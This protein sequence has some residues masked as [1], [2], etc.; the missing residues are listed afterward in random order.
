VEFESLG[1]DPD[2]GRIARRRQMDRG[3][4]RIRQSG[5]VAAPALTG[6]VVAR[7]GQ[8]FWTFAVAAGFALAGAFFY[9]FAFG[10]IEQVDGRRG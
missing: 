6:L 1:A 4:E 10:R 7:T 5:G 8:F 9:V 2:A 3:A